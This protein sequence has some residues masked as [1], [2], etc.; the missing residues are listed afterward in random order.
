MNFIATMFD[1]GIEDVGFCTFKCWTFCLQD[2]LREGRGGQSRTVNFIL[3]IMDFGLK[4]MDFGLIVMDFVL[5]M[6]DSMLKIPTF[7]MFQGEA[8]R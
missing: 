3:K 1:F 5:K 6:R 8:G 2:R 7:L 4:I